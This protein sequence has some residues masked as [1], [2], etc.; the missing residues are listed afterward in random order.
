MLKM[1]I[2]IENVRPRFGGDGVFKFP[3]F[4]LDSAKVIR[5]PKSFF[6]HRRAF[7]EIGNLL[8][9]ADLKVG[10][11]RDRTAVGFIDTVDQLEK[12]GL[13][14]AICADQADFFGWIDL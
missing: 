6:E 7:M 5:S 2:A 4:A 12:C 3:H 10:L 1:G 11:A 14:C 9:R 13:P 8:E